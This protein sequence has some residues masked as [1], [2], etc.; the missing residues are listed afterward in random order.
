MTSFKTILACV[1]LAAPSWSALPVSVTVTPPIA[2]PGEKVTITVAMKG[3]VSQPSTDITVSTVASYDEVD[4]THVVIA[5]IYTVVTVLGQPGAMVRNPSWV[6]TAPP[7]WL[8]ATQPASVGYT[9]PTAKAETGKITFSAA[10]LD[11]D[12]L[13]TT[14][15]DMIVAH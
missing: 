2:S 1:I 8:M 14:S 13:A 7:G 10:S 12:V 6:F 5:P 15:W 11:A 4:G 9:T 3:N